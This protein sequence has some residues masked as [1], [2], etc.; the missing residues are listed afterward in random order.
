M[1]EST[2]KFLATPRM[3]SHAA[4]IE[5][6]RHIDQL[7][8]TEFPGVTIYFLRN[9]TLEALEPYLKVFFHKQRLKLRAL[10][11]DFDSPHQ[12]ILNPDSNLHRAKPEIIVLT[13]WPESLVAKY[14]TGDW[15]PSEVSDQIIR[16][17]SGLLEKTAGTIVCHT[18]LAPLSL[19]VVGKENGTPRN[20]TTAVLAVNRTLEDFCRGEKRIV[21]LNFDLLARRVGFDETIDGRGW[22]LFRAPLK[23]EFLK[24]WAESLSQIGAS[25]SGRTKKA[26]VLD[27]DNTLWGGLVGEEGLNGISLNP[28]SFP[29]S[30]Y[31]DFQKQI[32]SLH[33]QGV[34]ITLCS[35]NNEED[36]LEVLEK[37][38]HCLIRPEHLVGYRI[39]WNHKPQNIVELA[40]ELN[41]GLDSMVVV[42][43]S[44]VECDLIRNRLPET[45]VLQIPEN[46]YEWPK[47]FA[48]H[49]PFVMMSQSAEDT[50]RSR[51][52]QQE[53]VR[54]HHRKIF[55][56]IDDYLASLELK[57][58]IRKDDPRDI[59]RIAQLTQKTNQFNLTTRRHTE[60]Q[61]SEMMNSP[62]WSVYSLSA[63]D[64]F[65]DYGL[66]GV[67]IGTLSAHKLSID[68]FLMSCRILNRNL[69][70]AF[71]SR[72]LDDAE[73]KSG[74]SVIEACYRPT[75][76]NRQLEMFYEN[77]GFRMVDCQDSG[78]KKYEA[79]I[80]RLKIEMPPY[81]SVSSG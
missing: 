68:T 9:Y 34:L 21:L 38:P 41:I 66:T 54:R 52:Y 37:H 22:Y 19:P 13:L 62:D 48:E 24:V 14:E 65:G 47:V 60:G 11:S 36:V 10:F 27:C 78:E 5:M 59:P 70:K 73:K 20:L 46:I 57:G 61:I 4:A 40:E 29:G 1:L 75:Q 7:K 71:L 53:G 33:R 81:I 2:D 74:I 55:D 17:L 26:L 18:L 42:D 50:Q 72:F 51:M 30:V 28:H 44:P 76:K 80:P 15:N 58:I 45:E 8:E 79:E 67:I 25:L 49:N 6:A 43:D 35:K 23:Q 16:A 3:I 64:K 32:L 39:N 31:Y 77:L 63:S 56:N 12:E 69:E